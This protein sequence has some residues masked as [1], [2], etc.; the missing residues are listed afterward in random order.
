MSAPPREA[1][2]GD[3][4]SAVRMVEGPRW[5]ADRD[6]AVSWSTPSWRVTWEQVWWRDALERLHAGLCAHALW[7]GPAIRRELVV[8]ER[9]RAVRLLLE[10][11]AR[12]PAGPGLAWGLP[13]RVRQTPLDRCPPGGDVLWVPD[14]LYLDGA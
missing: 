1:R 5:I 9:A 6:R 7:A 2:P 13:L 14:T 8:D 4:V 10:T 12:E 11:V 3:L